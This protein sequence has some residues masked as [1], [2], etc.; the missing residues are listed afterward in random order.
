M[1]GG[2]ESNLT[3][4][5]ILLEFKLALSGEGSK[6]VTPGAEGVEIGG[7]VLTQAQRRAD[8]PCPHPSLGEEPIPGAGGALPTSKALGLPPTP[9]PRHSCWTK[10]VWRT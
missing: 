4:L 9:T 10:C 3:P 2:R 5:F 7:T 1:R 8:E 6:V